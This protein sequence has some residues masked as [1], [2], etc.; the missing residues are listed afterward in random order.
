MRVWRAT[1]AA[2]TRCRFVVG[3][4]LMLMVAVRIGCRLYVSRHYAVK[5]LDFVLLLAVRWGSCSGR[6]D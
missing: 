3:S 4:V 1:A 2:R 5:G 6:D